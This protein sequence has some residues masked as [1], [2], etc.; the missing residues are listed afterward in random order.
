MKVWHGFGSEHSANLVMIGRFKTAKDAKEAL[1]LIENITAQVKKDQE[2]KANTDTVTGRYGREML[3]LLT[4]ANFVTVGA[5][6]L[7]QFVYEVNVTL[8]GNELILTTEEYD[9]SA[10]LKLLI[11]HGARL[12]VYSAHDYPATGLGRG[13]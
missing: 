7:E 8:D 9:V 12:D 4:N 1:A 2:N 11:H 10:F 13:G 3:D 6:E 5:S